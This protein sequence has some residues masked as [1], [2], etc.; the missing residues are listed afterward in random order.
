M[1]E[2]NIIAKDGGYRSRKLIFAVFT[3]VLILASPLLIPAVT[4][5][6]V[7]SGL[8]AV[9]GVYITGN[10]ITKWR[11]SSIEQAKVALQKPEV[12]PAVKPEDLS[13]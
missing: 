13:D 12:K 3:S 8:V 5:G 11:A 4:L 6:E 1:Q 2:E 7:I 9:A 10:V